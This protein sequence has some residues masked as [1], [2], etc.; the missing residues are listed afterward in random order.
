MGALG[1]SEGPG[2]SSVVCAAQIERPPAKAKMKTAEFA[3]RLFFI[4]RLISEL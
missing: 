2:P 4:D 1:C 3:N